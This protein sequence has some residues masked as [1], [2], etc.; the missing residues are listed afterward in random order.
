MATDGSLVKLHEISLALTSSPVYIFETLPQCRFDKRACEQIPLVAGLS[1]LQH[2][3]LGNALYHPGELN[4]LDPLLVRLFTCEMQRISKLS[5]EPMKSPQTVSPNLHFSI[6]TAIYGE[7]L[8][9]LI[10]AV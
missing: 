5:I 8:G 2:P 4:L 7:R 9:L 6:F 1:Q 10:A 3:S